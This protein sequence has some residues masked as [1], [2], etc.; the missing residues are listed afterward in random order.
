MD[1]HEFFISIFNFLKSIFSSKKN[2]FFGFTNFLNEFSILSGT[3]P[4]NRAIW[5]APAPEYK[6]SKTKEKKKKVFFL[7]HMAKKRQKR[8][9]DLIS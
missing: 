7:I 2:F 8:F 3:P 5:I 9:L 6:S 4:K 1:L